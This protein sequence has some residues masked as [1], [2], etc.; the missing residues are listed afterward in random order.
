[1]ALIT[2]AEARD[3]LPGITDEGTLLDTLIGAIGAAFA[4]RCGYPPASVGAAPTMESA[5]YTLDHDGIGGRDLALRVFPATA[6]T[7]VY[8]D[9]DRDFTDSTRLV[10]SAD[11]VI[12][13]GGR[14]L[15]LKSTA[16][17]GTWGRGEGR[18][19]VAFTAGYATVPAD[20]KDLAKRA[21][22]WS[23]E[24]RRTQGKVSESSEGS[25]VT[26]LESELDLPPF[27]LG[28]LG[29]FALGGRLS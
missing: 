7:S 28:A 10:P 6:I 12:V 14:T 3:V 13:N 16:T 11:Y 18:I 4:R 1:M 24:Q 23:F 20:L 2:A 27:I 17:W 21:V 22:K 25:S 29:Q 19:R 15:R 26:F 9:P 8:D 5:S